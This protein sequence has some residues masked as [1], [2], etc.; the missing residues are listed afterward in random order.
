MGS[1]RVRVLSLAADGFF[2]CR[3][4]SACFCFVCVFFLIPIPTLFALYFFFLFFS[5]AFNF[6]LKKSE[7]FSAFK[8]NVHKQ[9]AIWS[10]GG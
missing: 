8:K 3:F 9:A 2:L 7:F 6:S 10:R 5:F 4:L 1:S